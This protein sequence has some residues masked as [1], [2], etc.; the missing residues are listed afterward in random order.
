MRAIHN[1]ADISDLEP[2]H[3]LDGRQLVYWDDDDGC[4]RW[5]SCQY[6]GDDVLTLHHS[7]RDHVLPSSKLICEA[8]A[9]SEGDYDP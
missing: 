8:C 3:R 2:E 4:W 5:A 6:C 9:T 1:L 7:Y